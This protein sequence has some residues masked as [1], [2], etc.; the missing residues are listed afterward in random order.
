MF[1][2]NLDSVDGRRYDMDKFMELI[3]DG[4]DPL[5][6]ALFN[7]VQNLELGGRYTVQGEDE[8][9]DLL[10]FRIFDTTDY[11][12]IIMLYN[13]FISPSDIKTG[14]QVVFP[15]LTALENYYFNLKIR[16]SVTL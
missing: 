16:E 1:F 11:W 10:S 12:W 3:N 4:H 6:S 9:P 13:S 8:R 5:T 15:K 14:E 2:I 7:E